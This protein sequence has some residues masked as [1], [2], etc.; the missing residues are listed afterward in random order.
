MPVDAVIFD[1]DGLMLDTEPVYR[2][3]WQRASAECGYAISDELHLRLLGLKTEDAEQV[4]RQEFGAGF[5]VDAFRTLCSEHEPAAF[6]D[7]GLRKKSGLDEL[8]ALLNARRISKAVATSASRDRA[9]SLLSTTAVLGQFD[10]VVTGDEVARGKP[11]PDLFLLA[12]RR[13][14]TANSSCLVLEDAE[15]GVLAAHAAGMQVFVVPDLKQPSADV[16]KLAAGVFESLVA[17]A[18]HLEM[19]STGATRLNI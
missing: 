19:A 17:V 7:Y 1:M 8:L 6:R 2:M 16:V 14:E 9:L 12:A 11:S 3:A 15:A 13:L 5:S 4:L 18:K 10:V